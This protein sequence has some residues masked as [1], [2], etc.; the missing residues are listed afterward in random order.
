MFL[1]EILDLKDMIAIDRI[2]KR[3]K[4]VPNFLKMNS[5]F[6]DMEDIM[7]AVAMDMEAMEEEKDMVIMLE[8]MVEAMGDIMGDTEND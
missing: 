7:E 6:K 1:L 2:R 3:L 5:R 4:H 8:V